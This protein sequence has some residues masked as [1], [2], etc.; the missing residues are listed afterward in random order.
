MMTKT[1]LKVPTSLYAI[2]VW[3]RYNH[4]LQMEVVVRAETVSTYLLILSIQHFLK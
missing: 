3:I 1:Y 2:K 4:R